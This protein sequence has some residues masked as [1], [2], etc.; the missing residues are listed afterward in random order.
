MP[1]VCL[2]ATMVVARSATGTLLFRVLRP[3][4]S[5]AGAEAEGATVG[6][7]ETNANRVF[8]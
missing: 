8:E 4:R 5:P 2:P 6:G 7:E 1:L 3:L